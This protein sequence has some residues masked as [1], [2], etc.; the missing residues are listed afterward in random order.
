VTPLR[1]NGQVRLNGELWEAVS[2][3]GA[4]PGDIVRVDAVEGLTLVVSRSTSPS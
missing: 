1:P 2:D 4:D 3:E